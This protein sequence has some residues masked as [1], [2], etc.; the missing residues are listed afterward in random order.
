MSGKVPV[1]HRSVE[2]TVYVNHVRLDS[3]QKIYHTTNLLVKASS[4][5]CF[6]GFYVQILVC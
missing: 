3:F 1:Q 6:K 2:T 5:T 4:Q